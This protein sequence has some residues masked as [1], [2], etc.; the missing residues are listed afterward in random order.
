MS[1]LMLAVENECIEVAKVLLSNKDLDINEK[2]GLDST[3]LMIA[4]DKGSLD[5]VKVLLA[6]SRYKI[7]FEIKYKRNGQ[8]AL[9]FA[10]S[11]GY[12]EIVK[13]LLEAGANVN[14]QSEDERLTAL[15]LATENDHVDVVK[16]LLA[17]NSSEHKKVDTNIKN[18]KGLTAF[19]LAGS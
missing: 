16:E 3:A 19:D 6:G 8:T 4:A 15:M 14:E 18:K 1:P 13:K 17:Y 11:K 9:M 5:M 12:V 10:A 7:N 2:D